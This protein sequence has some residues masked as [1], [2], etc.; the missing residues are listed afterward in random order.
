MANVSGREKISHTIKMSTFW[1]CLVNKDTKYSCTLN[2]ETKFT[3]PS[4]NERRILIILLLTFE[5]L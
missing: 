4:N 3:C 2:K 1:G 5:L